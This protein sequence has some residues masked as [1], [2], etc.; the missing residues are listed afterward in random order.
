MAT[1]YTKSTATGGGTGS[2]SSEWTLQEAADNAV[3]GDLVLI[4]A[5]ANYVETTA[6]DFD[7]NDGT[8]S[9]PISFRGANSDGTD[10]GTVATIDGTGGSTTNI[11]Y[12]NGSDFLRFDNLRFTNATKNGVEQST[13]TANEYK[14][15]NCRFDNCTNA[16]YYTGCSANAQN[17]LMVDCEFDNNEYGFNVNSLFSRGHWGFI[18]C[19]IHDNTKN[20]LRLDAIKSVINCLIW[21]NGS[22]G[23]YAGILL[24]D[25]GG[26]VAYFE[27]SIIFGNTGDGLALDPPGTFKI[28]VMANCIF[29]SNGGYGI[30][31]DTHPNLNSFYFRNSCFSNNDG[32]GTGLDIDINSNVVPGTGHITSDPKFTN[33][34]SGVEDFSLQSDSPCIAAGIDG[35]L[36]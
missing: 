1:Y 13:T 7:T 19:N 32:G 10:D 36:W 34:G 29:R 27:N 12:I 3:A 31:T 24:G 8:N 5:D 18:R 23:T 4:K 25:G 15:F 20:G 2:I 28:L 33:E 17:N 22:D 16:G 11:F 9:N 14:F 35:G 26:S 21:N 6:I 30:N